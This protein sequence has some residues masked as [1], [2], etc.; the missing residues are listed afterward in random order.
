MLGQL[1][2]VG[3]GRF[4]PQGGIFIW[5]HD[6]NDICSLPPSAVASIHLTWLWPCRDTGLHGPR[7]TQGDQGCKAMAPLEGYLEDKW[8]GRQARRLDPLVGTW[9]PTV[10]S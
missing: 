1:P 4:G 2:G 7:K 8:V 9:R 10:S 3:L 5:V 6:L